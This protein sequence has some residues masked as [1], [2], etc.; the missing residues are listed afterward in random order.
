M[1]K[2]RHRLSTKLMILLVIT[3][4]TLVMTNLILIFNLNAK[5]NQLIQAIYSDAYNS[6]SLILNADRDLYQAVTAQRTLLVS[7]PQSKDFADQLKSYQ[8]NIN[9]VKERIVKA[10]ETFLANKSVFDKIQNP[11]SSKTVFQDIEDFNLLFGA[12][13]TESNTLIDSL[14]HVS[15]NERENLYKKALEIET[16]FET[17]RD[18]LNDMEDLLDDYARSTIE[19]LQKDNQQLKLKLS[20]FIGVI[21]LLVAILGWRMIRNI[22]KSLAALAG[23]ANQV[24]AGDLSLEQTHFRSRDEISALGQALMTMADNLKNMISGISSASAHLVQSSGDLGQSAEQTSKASEQI[25][26][27]IQEV[28]TGSEYQVKVVE[29]NSQ[30]FHDISFSVKQIATNAENATY[31]ANEALETAHSGEDF[32][33]TMISQMQQV[34]DTVSGLAKT[35]KGLGD[36][37]Q[38]IEQIVTVITGIAEQ[39]NLL[40]LN[41]AIEAAR[42]GEYGRGF[43]V[44][45]EEVRKLA[46]QSADSTMQI[47]QLVQAIQTETR[48]TVAGT[49]SMTSIVGEGLNVANEAGTAFAKIKSSVANVAEQIQGVSKEVRHISDKTEQII[50]S[51][52]M[53]AKVATE[54]AAGTQ[55][56]S[57]A[58]EQQL[59][60]MEE[61][62]S[63]VSELSK[64]ANELEL[65][66]KKFK[67]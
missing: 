34:S 8:E 45:A 54:T 21:I 11:D 66:V 15:I 57:A 60:S 32:I 29:E 3:L 6:A 13:E 55:N 44:V 48:N 24:A 28:A 67:V 59:A 46:E 36:S 52:N 33:Q 35:V 50:D 17:A 18:N 27:T 23:S 56:I 16:K 49:A 2:L 65:L 10:K 22:T 26:L 9:Q 64:M 62:H 58:A 25:T 30:L 20:F 51:T 5:T 61:I 53:I 12:W 7:N 4:I 63:S 47:K 43:A 38:E 37:S 1:I 31:A 42:A 14:P 41:A 19:V 39:T 40:A